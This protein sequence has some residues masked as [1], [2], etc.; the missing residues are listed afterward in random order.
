[1]VKALA[2][3]CWQ[4]HEIFIFYSASR[5]TLV[6]TKPPIQ[7]APGGFPRGKS[8]WHAKSTAHLSLVTRLR[9]PGAIP[10]LLHAII[11]NTISQNVNS[12]IIFSSTTHTLSESYKV[13]RILSV[14]S[15]N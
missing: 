13:I 14:F 7:Q 1:M 12:T 9:I 15:N 8:R 5:L 6:P 10:P 2:F 4:K 11:A 3:D